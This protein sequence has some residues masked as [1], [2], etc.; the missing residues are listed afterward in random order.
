MPKRAREKTDA[1]KEEY[2]QGI[3]ELC[4]GSACLPHPQCDVY[5]FIDMHWGLCDET[6]GSM[7]FAA[8]FVR[9]LAAQCTDEL[10]SC[11]A[12]ALVGNSPGYIR[13]L[14]PAGSSKT[15]KPRDER[16]PVDAIITYAVCICLATKFA[17]NEYINAEVLIRALGINTDGFDLLHW[18]LRVFKALG[19]RL[20]P[21]LQ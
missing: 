4:L 2:C 6:L 21:K 13:C 19:W 8:G 17:S 1:E 16:S 20:G 3:S 14:W 12:A 15:H 18:E 5:R 11:H 9:R 7:T 10:L